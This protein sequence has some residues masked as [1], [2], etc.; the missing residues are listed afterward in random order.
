MIKR[1]RLKAAF[2]II[3]VA[4]VITVVN[5]GSSLILIHNTLNITMSEDISLAR[6]IVNDFI[7]TRIDLY[8]S[9]ARTVA[10]HF[11][12][13]DSNE[14]METDMQELLAEYEDFMAFTVFNRQGIV[15]QYGDSPTSINLLDQ[16]KY[17]ESAFNGRTVIS[18]T[19]YNEA[20]NKLVMYICTPMG[21]DR[22]LS[23][24]ISGMI[25]SEMLGSYILRDTRKIFMLDEYGTVI[26]HFSPDIVSSRTNVT[27]DQASISTS[28]N[29]FN[30]IL[31]N[32]KGQGNYIINDVDYQCAYAKILSSQTDW[33]ICLSVPAH[34]NL[35]DKL[36]KRLL[37]LAVIF[38]AAGAA[39]AVVCS[40]QIARP[41]NK[42]AEQNRRLEEL[43]SETRRLQ[44]ELEDA[45]KEA[46][47]A[48]RAKSDFLANM[49]HEMRTP[50][51][52][53]VGL[54]ELILNERA[55]SKLVQ[56][57]Q[58]VWDEVE[59]KI[60]R[61]YSSGMTL[62]GIVNDILDISKIE[63][64]KFE[65]HPVNYDTASLINDIV[66]QNIVR[67]GNKPIQFILFVDEKLPRQLF[68]DDLRIKQVFNNLLSNAFKYTNSGTVKW[69]LSFRRDN[70]NIW[71]ISE[72]KDT[73][74]GIKREDLQ[75]LFKDY[76]QVGS[77][78]KTESTGLGLSIT[79]SLVGMMNGTITAESEYGKGMTFSL[80]LRQDFVS[81]VPIGLE[82]AGNLMS[83]CFTDDRIAQT[84]LERMDL[85]HARVLVVD[86]IQ[87]NLDV[88][89]GMLAP[90]GLQVDC[91]SCG[92]QA[93]EMVCF[94]NP[95][96]DAIF[97]DH[98]MPGIDGIETVRIIREEIDTDYARSVPVIALTANAITGNEKMFLEHGF[99]AFI[100]K[101][102]NM[103]R[104]DSILRRW[105]G[106]VHEEIESRE[107]END[108]KRRPKKQMTAL[109]YFN[110]IFI[111]GINI[112]S[113]LES[114]TGNEEIY[115]KVLQSYAQNTRPLIT[116]LKKYLECGN[117]TDY[118]VT[119]HGIK[120]SSY[121]IGAM[122]AGKDA[123]RLELLVKDFLAS[124]ESLEPHVRRH[125]I[126][127][128]D[129]LLSENE[130]FTKLMDILLA[131][132]ESALIMISNKCGKPVAV[133]PDPVLLREL[134]EA[135]VEYDIGKVDKVM[136]KL[137]SFKYEKGGA[138]ITW[139]HEQVDDM[140]FSEISGGNW[141]DF[142]AKSA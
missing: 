35:A 100:S 74:M 80:Q 32:N 83:S 119:V 48:D 122:R 33:Y 103:K 96:Y 41:Y 142:G 9:N 75:K 56:P 45:L 62:L 61:I 53:V 16:S 49:S 36:E 85:S 30:D 58:I 109:S 136:E 108:M 98:M 107:D 87:T 88:A 77:N 112:D 99:Q 7:S 25:F 102:I 128:I 116:D 66:S 113:T 114:F 10:E 78:R 93:I 60:G 72:V 63:S 47:D 89:K 67:I 22:I 34:E 111:D 38:F 51:N 86:D 42:V 52:A 130:A 141:P 118:T 110:G 44:T 57:R 124:L 59:D 129:Y 105:V 55:L 139:L 2:I 133:T 95:C 97:M 138:L 24:T 17:I 84:A 91:A 125:M 4:F 5:I 54:S 123:Q 26:A 6:D 3:V 68:G 20:T 37:V 29:F 65:L 19:K 79:K 12:T 27:T 43:M 131:S 135:C 76:S 140:S 92:R 82:T 127:K 71:L 8:K 117:L 39:I 81:D 11:I 40:G 31:T 134:R 120:G 115:I 21:Q 15:A 69:K 64:G 13:N 1:M 23:V 28:I 132:I 137:D 73:G 106:N 50:L 90:Y 18:T 104:L 94:E 121:S 46:M 70:E 126:E 14:D 101:P